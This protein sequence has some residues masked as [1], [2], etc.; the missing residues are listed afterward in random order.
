MARA[1]TGGSTRGATEARPH[2]RSRRR[3]RA[4]TYTAKFTHGYPRPKGAT[5]LVRLAR[6]R[7]RGLHDAQSPARPT[8]RLHSC[9]NPALTS[10]HLTVGTPDANG[11][12]LELHGR[13]APRRDPDA[14]ARPRT[15][16]T[17][18]CVASAKDVRNAGDLSDYAGE[19]VIAL[20]LR[21]TDK[22]NSASPNN[23]GTVSDTEL[24]VPFQCSTT[25]D[26]GRRGVVLDD[27]RP[28]RGDPR[29]RDAR[30]V[31]RSGSCVRSSFTMEAQMGLPR[32]TTTRCSRPRASSCPDLS[33]P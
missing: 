26:A 29:N 6:T 31:A 27:H 10:Q 24:S 4:T 25:A 18:G 12:G 13:G 33:P 20:P 23:S 28:R 30:D 7:L 32:P 14:P 19:V 1:R 2:T 5:P 8:P 17:C 9:S 21:L 15:R 22:A 11:S 16:P 3:R